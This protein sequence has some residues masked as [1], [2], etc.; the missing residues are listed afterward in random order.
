MKDNRFTGKTSTEYSLLTKAMPYYDELQ[1][2]VGLAIVHHYQNCSKDI[3][4]VL[5]VG[6]GTG[7]TAKAI[8]ENEPR[9]VVTTVDKEQSMLDQARKNLEGYVGR[10]EFIESD[11]LDYLEGLKTSFDS[12]ASGITLHNF[13]RNSRHRILKLIFGALV[14]GSLFVNA[15]KYALDDPNEHRKLLDW[16]VNQY[17]KIFLREGK[18]DLIERWIDHEEYDHQ[19]KILM[20]E[21]ES[22]R[23]MEQVGFE[24]IKII[25]R[26]K[27]HAVLVATKK[28]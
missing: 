11:A 18:P 22:I 17:I 10:V 16:Q 14:P 13:E 28:S 24:N 8:L 19:S 7:F 26:N 5:E 6:T 4:R 27:M 1:Q 21:G 20:E 3:I 12:F 25:Y 2:Q 23:E 15:D 9:A